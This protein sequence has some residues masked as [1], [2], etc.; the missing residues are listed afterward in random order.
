MQL[1]FSSVY[2]KANNLLLAPEDLKALAVGFARQIP[3]VSDDRAIRQVADAHTI[4][5]WLTLDLLKL[6]VDCNR[7]D[8]AK[9]KEI[10]EYWN[11]E[12]DLPRGLPEVRTRYQH[13]FGCKCPV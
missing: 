8:L 4:D 2:A 11:H 5:C 10:I 7:V 12:N 6:M 9:V 3:V 1:P 13:L